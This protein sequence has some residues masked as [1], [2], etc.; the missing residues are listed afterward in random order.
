MTCIHCQHARIRKSGTY[1]KKRIQR[2]RCTFCDKTFSEPQPKPLG[3][4]R[5]SVEKAVQI[6]NCL[7]EGCG[8]RST[9]RLCDVDSKTVLA[10]LE[11]AGKK[12]QRLLDQKLRSIHAPH[13]QC[14]EIWTFVQKKEKRIK[15]WE[16][17]TEIGSQFIYVAFDRDSKL[18]I[19]Y[20]IGKR[21]PATT[22]LFVADLERRV[23][24]RVQISTDGYGA[25]RRAIEDTFGANVDYAQ[26]VKVYQNEPARRFFSGTPW[27]PNRPLCPFKVCT[28]DPDYHIWQSRTETYLY[29]PRRTKQSHHADVHATTDKAIARLLK[30]A[31]ESETRDST[32]FRLVQFCQDSQ[33]IEGDTGDGKRSDQSSLEALRIQDLVVA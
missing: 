21:S 1:G 29:I 24:G 6:V 31:G 7:V 28:G 13:I 26:L 22:R 4:L 3:K 33:N 20:E 17:G 19:N 14:D 30:E 8:I 18:V 11:V 10:V 25:Y 27:R 32:V 2:Y 9:A 5:I 16:T 12:C 15:P 23:L